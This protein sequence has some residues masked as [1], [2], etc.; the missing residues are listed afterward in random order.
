MAHRRIGE[1]DGRNLKE[2]GNSGGVLE[3]IDDT[4]NAT[5]F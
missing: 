2:V 3:A 5:D 4:N 1:S